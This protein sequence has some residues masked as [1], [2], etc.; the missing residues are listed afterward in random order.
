MEREVRR[1]PNE[2]EDEFD[3]LRARE[4]RTA[5][6]DARRSKHFDRVIEVAEGW[7]RGLKVM[8]CCAGHEVSSPAEEA[9]ADRQNL[10]RSKN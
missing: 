7:K 4:H 8:R 3:H 1:I 9:G 2:V 6:F 5:L 10:E